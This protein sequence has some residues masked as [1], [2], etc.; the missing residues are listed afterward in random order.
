MNIKWTKWGRHGR[1]SRG[2]SPYDEIE[3]LLRE[4]A[5]EA[6]TLIKENN[7]AH[8]LY[9]IKRFNEYGDLAE[10]NLYMLPLRETEFTRLVLPLKN[11]EIY[12]IHNRKGE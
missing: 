8:V 2:A 3:K 9:G 11:S 6:G 1:V 12:A 7:V 5:K 4:N 10:V